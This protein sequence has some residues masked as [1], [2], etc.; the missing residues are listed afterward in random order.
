MEY[1]FKRI[2]P[3]RVD[4]AHANWRVHLRV[5]YGKIDAPIKI[6]IATGDEIIPGLIEYSFPLM[7]EDGS[8]RVLSY[9]LET[10][11]AEKLKTWCRATSRTRA[12]DFEDIVDSTL[13]L[14]RLVELDK[15]G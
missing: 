1:S 3:I 12:G 9:P 13:E 7:F 14:A 2:E 15:L 5:G 6:D 4:V 11:L 8:V 10:V